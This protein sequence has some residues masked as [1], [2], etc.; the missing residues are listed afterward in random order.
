MKWFLIL[1]VCLCLFAIS[2]PAEAACGDGVC[3]ARPLMVA[4]KAAVAV[5]RVA[6]LPVR[7]V[8]AVQPIRSVGRAI[9]AVKP[10]RRAA[11]VASAPVRLLLR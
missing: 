11:R 9:V 6:A 10:V 4:G 2:S 1:L 7:A 3:A 5:G 8:A